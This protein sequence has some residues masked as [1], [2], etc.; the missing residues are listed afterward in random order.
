MTLHFTAPAAQV[1]AAIAADAADDRTVKGL[2]VPY[3]VSGR[4]D[5]GD[6]KVRAGGLR[7]PAD[8]RR[9][10]LF[11]DHGRATPVGYAHTVTD[12]ADAMRMAFRV[13]GTP[14]GDLAL[15]EAAEG[16]RDALSVELDNADIR[17]GWIESADVVA[18]ALVPLP[19]YADARIN[20][21]AATERN[22]RM[23]T[24]PDPDPTT[25]TP[26]DDDEDTPAPAPA[27]TPPP[28]RVAASLNPSPG[29][30]VQVNASQAIDRLRR[31]VATAG[32]AAQVNAALSDVVPGDDTGQGFMRD[33]WL[34]ELWTPV[35]S[36]RPYIA[37]MTA[38][39]LTG[40]RFYGWKW[41][42][43]PQVGP[44]AGNKAAIPSNPVRIVPVEG[45]AYRLA[46]G[47][48]VDRILVDLG[49]PG[50]LEALFAAAVADY[51]VKSNAAAGTFL[52]ANATVLTNTVDNL[53][54][55]LAACAAAL[56]TNGATVS[57]IAI[58]ADLWSDYLALTSAEAPWWLSIAAGSV[59]IKSPSGQV[60][61]LSF[62][63]DPTLPAGTILAGDK[64]ATQH[65][66]AA[67]SPLKV[68]AENI[69]SGGIDIGV[70]GYAG[71]LLTDGRGLVKIVV[72]AGATQS[73]RTPARSSSSK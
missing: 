63:V 8:L 62:F 33:Q 9:V 43:T 56:A 7:T 12:T 19:A 15:V 42:E 35:A 70:F 60:A 48:D 50:F 38:G 29:R 2:V 13:A 3:G 46:G 22:P 34:G 25:T 17:G 37:S 4:T 27:P 16:V 20:A 57:W 47:W 1:T 32:D 21:A 71:D 44:Y 55:G 59:S 6:L 31:V 28:A 45:T 10:K 41:E 73:A 68:R 26:D 39:T 18:V 49:S 23:T 61:D 69:P 58:A 52:A 54:D 30:R 66:E 5:A 14:A 64:R 72:A 24:A 40:M 51:G 53:V 11:T 36:Q 67:G 65:F